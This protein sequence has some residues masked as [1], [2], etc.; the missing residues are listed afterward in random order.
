MEYPKPT[1]SYD[2]NSLHDTQ[3]KLL[4]KLDSDSRYGVRVPI[5]T[6][7]QKNLITN[8]NNFGLLAIIKSPDTPAVYS[9][10]I[11]LLDSNGDL[12]WKEV[13]LS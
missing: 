13:G 4:N 3:T 12:I 2:N 10:N 11:S 6:E 1:L 5:L 7:G 8:K 9:L